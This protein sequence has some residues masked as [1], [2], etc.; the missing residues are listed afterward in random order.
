MAVYCTVCLTKVM[1]E[2][3]HEEW[4]QN[5]AKTHAKRKRKPKKKVEDEPKK[6]GDDREDE[7]NR[8]WVLW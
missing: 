6:S 7:A 1:K 4:L 8:N 5:H 2:W 3:E